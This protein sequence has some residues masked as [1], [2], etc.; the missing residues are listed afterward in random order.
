MD[1]YLQSDMIQLSV[2]PRGS[3][4]AI[5]IPLLHELTR[6]DSE[7]S[8]GPHGAGGPVLVPQPHPVLLPIT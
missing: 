3:P 5:F 6:S 1:V 8:H 4:T 2:L 7:D